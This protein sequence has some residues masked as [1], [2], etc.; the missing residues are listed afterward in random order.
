MEYNVS[1]VN[2]SDFED[3][4]DFADKVKEIRSA[5]LLYCEGFP[6]FLGFGLAKRLKLFNTRIAC[7]R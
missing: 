3:V 2:Q 6:L 5:G 7:L 4:Y 1:L